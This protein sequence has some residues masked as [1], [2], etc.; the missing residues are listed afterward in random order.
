[1]TPSGYGDVDAEQAKQG[2]NGAA[3]NS[4]EMARTQVN[5]KAAAAPA[6]APM[7]QSGTIT[8]AAN[9][10]TGGKARA[11]EA[12]QA[13]GDSA[14]R[15]PLQTSQPLA[16]AG[17]APSAN[18]LQAVVG[19]SPEVRLMPTDAAAKGDLSE[20]GA[21]QP[22]QDGEVIR[23]VAMK[24]QACLENPGVGKD[25]P[26]S[27]SS[28]VCHG[29]VVALLSLPSSSTSSSASTSPQRGASAG[30][31]PRYPKPV[32]LCAPETA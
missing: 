18:L 26:E 22:R 17:L 3:E 10:A 30:L 2:G 8:E 21:E 20:V 1:M 13:W 23:P 28:E 27:Q 12:D 25:T 32:S 14:V 11:Q 4:E 7:Q 16:Q 31:P 5:V 15:T 9:A 24:S 6:P 19:A 29:T